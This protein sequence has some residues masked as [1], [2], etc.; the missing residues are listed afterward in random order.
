MTTD[1]EKVLIAG[2]W[3]G[4]TRW[5]VD[6]IWR[7]RKLLEG[8]E[9]KVILHLGDFGFWPYKVKDWAAGDRKP[10]GLQYLLDVQSAL[11]LADAHLWVTPG[12]H[13]DYD[14][15]D[16]WQGYARDVRVFPQTPLGEMD[17]IIVLPR[18]DRWAWHGRTWL[19]VGGAVSVDRLLPSPG[20][21]PHESWWPQE[22]VTDEQEAAIIAG[23]HADVMVCHDYPVRV[24]HSFDHHF[25]PGFHPDDL[26]RAAR[27]QERMQRIV[28]AVQPSHYMHGHLHRRYGRT[29]DW[30]WGPVKI[31]GL[32]MDGSAQNFAVLDVRDM[33]WE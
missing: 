13:D 26:W 21:F 10:D 18:G 2:D 5:A 30:G 19:S 32:G 25:Q 15:M 17:R 16:R 28:D 33:T 12:N 9:L 22:E 8:E 11:E 1:P 6:V 7:A 20:R 24:Q 31:T 4:N 29:Y 3:H 27:H 23:G 14:A